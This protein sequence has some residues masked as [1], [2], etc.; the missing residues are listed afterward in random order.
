MDP[1][2]QDYGWDGFFSDAFDALDATELQPARVTRSAANIF[3]VRGETYSGQAVLAGKLRHAAETTADLPTVGDW[4]G[5]RCP[6]DG[7]ARIEALLPR[8]S[9]LSRKVA[10]KRAHE[11]VVAANVDLVIVM[12]ALDG[13]FNLRRLE[14]YLTAI[15]ESGAQPL[16]LLN[17]TDLCD[18]S[19]ERSGEV[20]QVAAGV[21]VL[22]ASCKHGDGVDAVREHIGPGRTAVLV[23]SSGAGKSTLINRLLGEIVQRTRSVRE[24]DDRGRHTTTHRELFLLPNGGLL[25]D[26]PG[27]RELQVWGGEQSLAQAFDDIE[28]MAADCRFRDCSHESEAGCAVLAA[29]EAGGLESRRLENYHTL[30]KELRYLEMKQSEAAQRAQKKKRR[31]LHREYKRFVKKRGR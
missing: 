26:S 3:R 12:M 25:I 1:A 31:G 18:E 11:Q 9:A 13:D 17:K 6:Q 2:L 27:I 28:E 4:V 19:A 29:V 21:P 10:G 16:V 30:Q 8:R 14:R 15:W 22:Q 7:D 5:I 24:D 20:E 23:G